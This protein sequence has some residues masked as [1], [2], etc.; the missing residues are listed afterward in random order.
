ML[1]FF[2]NKRLI[3]IPLQLVKMEDVLLLY[4]FH[5]HGLRNIR[6]APPELLIPMHQTY[7]NLTPTQMHVLKG[8]Y[9]KNKSKV[10]KLLELQ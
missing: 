4:F 10:F 9:E 6:Y 2:L 5:M 1:I 8:M 7:K 3:Y